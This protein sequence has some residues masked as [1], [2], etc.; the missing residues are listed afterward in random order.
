MRH[1][2]DLVDRNFLFRNMCSL[3]INTNF[4]RLINKIGELSSSRL[5]V[6]GYLSEDLAIE[7][8]VRLGDPLS[9]HLFV[10]YLQPL[11]KKLE[12]I[13]GPDLVVAYADDE[14]VI[15]TCRN[16]MEQI[17]E[18]FHRFG[19]VSVAR[20]S[21]EKFTSISVGY[22]DD[23]P[24]IVPWLRCKNTLHILGVTFANCIRLMNKLNW[25]ALVGKFT[26]KCIFT[27]SAHSAYTKGWPWSMY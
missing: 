19:R 3:G 1:A 12:E 21:L 17:R 27:P 6:K 9:M 22:T 24:L 4:V 16:R 14:S 8:S 10:L 5:L 25:D 2:F 13:C 20:L 15:I 26:R 11:I 18:T 7:R 23:M